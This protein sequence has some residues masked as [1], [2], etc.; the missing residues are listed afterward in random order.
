MVEMLMLKGVEQVEGIGG[1]GGK[2]GYAI[3]TKNVEL[4]TVIGSYV[5]DMKK[6]ASD[7]QI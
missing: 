2:N 7:I 4:P 1:K 5:G 6:G 3:I